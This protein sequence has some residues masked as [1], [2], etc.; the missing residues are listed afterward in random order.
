MVGAARQERDP[1][2]LGVH[3]ASLA[4]SCRAFAART[5]PQ[6]HRRVAGKIRYKCLLLHPV[7]KLKPPG[8]SVLPAAP[9]SPAPPPQLPVCAPAPPPSSAG[10]ATAAHRRIHWWSQV[11]LCEA[12]DCAL[13]LRHHVVRLTAAPV[14]GGAGVLRRPAHLLHLSSPSSGSTLLCLLLQLSHSSN[15]VRRTFWKQAR[16]HRQAG[17]THA[18]LFLPHRMRFRPFCS[19]GSARSR[20][21][22]PFFPGR[23]APGRHLAAACWTRADGSDVKFRMNGDVADSMYFFGV[24]LRDVELLPVPSHPVWFSHVT[25]LAPS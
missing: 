25:D 24:C 21:L 1:Q 15:S 20:L 8:A 13:M 18:G 5:P 4:L 16:G 2:A 22:P 11:D 9:Q 23:S 17:R 19:W 6:T 12:G 14:T 7:L 3:E 10:M